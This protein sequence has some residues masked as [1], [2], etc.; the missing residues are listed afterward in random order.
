MRTFKVLLHRA[1]RS[2]SLYVVTTRDD[3][4]ARQ[5]ADDLMRS[6]DYLGVEVWEE[7]EMI[8]AVGKKTAG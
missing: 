7:D 5:I 1:Q 4:R 6:A 2:P 8:F 3:S